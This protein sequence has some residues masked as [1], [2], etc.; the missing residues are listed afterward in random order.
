[1]TEPTALQNLTD[2]VMAILIPAFLSAITLMIA[3][4]LFKLKEKLHI[5]VSKKTQ[6]AWT[7]LARNAAL[8]GAEWARAKTKELVKDAKL[9]G[10]ATMEVAVNWALQMAE[11]QGLPTLAREKLIGLIESELY[12]LRREDSATSLP[13]PALGP[14]VPIA[15]AAETDGP[16]PDLPITS[17]LKLDGAI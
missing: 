6:E 8:R 3:W 10:G 5:D 15:P 13:E 9:P 7:E 1:M 16:T 17:I 14:P 12:K 4:V 2:Q 11:Q